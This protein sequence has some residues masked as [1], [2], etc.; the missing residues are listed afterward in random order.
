MVGVDGCRPW[1]SDCRGKDREE[2]ETKKKWEEREKGK[3]AE[4]IGKRGFVWCLPI[5]HPSWSQNSPRL[6]VKAPEKRMNI[7][8]LPSVRSGCIIIP[9]SEVR[10]RYGLSDWKRFK[11]FQFRPFPSFSLSLSFQ[12]VGRRRKV[13]CW[14]PLLRRPF[15]QIVITWNV[16]K[17][18]CEWEVGSTV[19][20]LKV[21]YKSNERMWMRGQEDF[22][23]E[24]VAHYKGTRTLEARLE[25]FKPA[26]ASR[27]KGDQVHFRYGH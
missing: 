8:D 19:G 22:W 12:W 6:L 25:R 7:D 9:L 16:S 24:C 3:E 10:N 14:V 13:V 4:K 5:S 17:E 23:E 21:D 2:G 27:W 11:A 15:F 1:S 18:G 20:E 26:L